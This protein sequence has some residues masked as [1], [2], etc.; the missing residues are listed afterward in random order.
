MFPLVFRNILTITLNSIDDKDAV[1]NILDNISY[2]KTRLN[3]ALKYVKLSNA[4]KQQIISKKNVQPGVGQKVQRRYTKIERGRPTTVNRL[5]KEGGTNKVN[6]KLITG[7]NITRLT[8][9]SNKWILTII[10]QGCMIQYM[11]K[12]K[13]QV[14]LVSLKDYLGGRDFRELSEEEQLEICRKMLKAL[15]P[16]L[17]NS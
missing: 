2:N 6:K 9:F 11:K 14:N 3:E 1:L 8:I 5:V 15:F 10:Q 17:P 7:A 16:D 12:Q 13:N 4:E